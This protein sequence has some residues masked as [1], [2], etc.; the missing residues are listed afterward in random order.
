MMNL[1]KREASSV[2]QNSHSPKRIRLSP[3]S[4]NESAEL[5]PVGSER[6]T[7]MQQSAK[8]WVEEDL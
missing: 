4:P 5:L 1:G 2:D 8:K 7:N 6:A 3:S